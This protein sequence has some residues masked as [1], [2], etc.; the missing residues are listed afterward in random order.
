[1]LCSPRL[2]SLCGAAEQLACWDTRGRQWVCLG[3]VGRALPPPPPS[4]AVPA[5]TPPGLA[6]PQDPLLWGRVRVRAGQFAEI[7]PDLTV[8]NSGEVESA[9]VMHECVLHGAL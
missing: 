2:Q 7:S 4:Q 1:M 9:A 8:W 5:A 3:A 6:S